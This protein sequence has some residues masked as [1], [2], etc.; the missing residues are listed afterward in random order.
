MRG[1]ATAKL[2]GERGECARNAAADEIHRGVDDAADLRHRLREVLAHLVDG[3][4]CALIAGRQGAENGESVGRVFDGRGRDPAALALLEIQANDACGARVLLEAALA[5]AAADAGLGGV[6]RHVADFTAGAER[7]GNELAAHND[8]RAHARAERDERVARDAARDAGPHLAQGG[9]IGVVDEGDGRVGER[10]I[11][12]VDKALGVELD[13]GQEAH[14]TVIGN[15]ARNVEAERDDVGRLGV[16]GGKNLCEAV[17]DN[18]VRVS[19]D[20][21][22]RRDLALLE[23]LTRRREEARLDARAA[24]VDAKNC[25]H[26]ESLL[27]TRGPFPR[28]RFNLFS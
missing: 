26:K 5:P 16:M 21:L 17:G 14:G 9:G 20:E 2:R 23:E 11:D 1:E 6:D 7:A 13:I 28:C 4:L 10:R 8:A 25:L 22:R 18:G 27:S 15:G 3:D 24:D 19:V 12:G